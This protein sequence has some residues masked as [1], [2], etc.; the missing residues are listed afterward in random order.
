MGAF[1]VLLLVHLLGDF[2]CQPYRL[3]LWKITSIRGLVAHVAIQAALALPVMVWLIPAWGWWWAVLVASHFLIDWVKVRFTRGGW[4]ELVAFFV[5]QVVHVLVLWA[6]VRLSGA[7]AAFSGEA[8]LTL[9]VAIAFIL[10]SYVGTVVVFLVGAMLAAPG[11][12]FAP[13]PT[14]ERRRGMVERTAI[15][16]GGLVAASLALSPI[17]WIV[18]SALYLAASVMRQRSGWLKTTVSIAWALV[19][20]LILVS[21]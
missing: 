15:L 17:L 16:I 9:R 19:V 7:D 12:Q 8:A 14:G 5:D 13:I 1:Q 4:I 18:A 6:I 10:A 11:R 2:P 20:T 21:V 3:F